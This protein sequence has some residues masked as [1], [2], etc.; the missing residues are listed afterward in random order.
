VIILKDISKKQDGIVWTGFTWRRMRAS[1]GF[2]Y[3]V[4]TKT[5][6]FH[7]KLCVLSVSQGGTPFYGVG[8]F[9]YTHERC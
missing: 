4:S 1:S 6:K 3:F 5:M 2:F 9:T 7:D 8:H